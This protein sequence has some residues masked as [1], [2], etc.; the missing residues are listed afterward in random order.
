ML[1]RMGWSSGKG[2]GANED[3]LATHL[4]VRVKRDNQGVGERGKTMDNWLENAVGFED[5]LRHLNS[6]GNQSGG[7]QNEGKRKAD[8]SDGEV[9]GEKRRKKK[10]K[11]MVVEEDGEEVDDAVEK[12]EIKKKKGKKAH[13]EVEQDDKKKSKKKAKKRGVEAEEDEVEAEREGK[14]NGKKSKKKIVEEEQESEVEEEETKGGKTDSEPKDKVDR[15][16]STGRLAH[17]RRF[18]RNKDVASYS[19]AD[20][21]GILGVAL[22]P[23]VKPNAAAPSNQVKA[24]VGMADYFGDRMKEKLGVDVESL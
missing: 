24:D 20:L 15:I 8:E 4:K 18:L 22:P 6:Q 2:L 1:E 3:G 21:S 13:V 11:V 14:K 17:R 12:E 9:E 23:T 7:D 16:L 10:K 19:S 5:V